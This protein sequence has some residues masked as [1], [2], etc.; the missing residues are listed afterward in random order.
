MDEQ[1]I[2]WFEALIDSGVV[3]TVPMREGPVCTCRKEPELID[4]KLYSVTDAGCAFHGVKS[5]HVVRMGEGT[6][7]RRDTKRHTAHGLG[8]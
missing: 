6:E 1:D 3:K 4:G 8:E 7:R 5:H 2:R